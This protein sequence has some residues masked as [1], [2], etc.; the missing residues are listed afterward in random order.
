MEKR[1]L[2]KENPFRSGLLLILSEKKHRE[3]F[4]RGSLSPSHG[5][6]G[7]YVGSTDFYRRVCLAVIDEL[8]KSGIV[9]AAKTGMAVYTYQEPDTLIQALQSISAPGQFVVSS[10]NLNNEVEGSTIAA[11][12]N[13]DDLAL[14][15]AYTHYMSGAHQLI[16]F[17]DCL[18]EIDNKWRYLLAEASQMYDEIIIVNPDCLRTQKVELADLRQAKMI[19]DQDVRHE[20][21]LSLVFEFVLP[22]EE[23]MLVKL[24]SIQ[25]AKAWKR[26][27]EEKHEQAER[28]RK[29][30]K[31]KEK[32]ALLIGEVKLSLETENCLLEMLLRDGELWGATVFDSN[33]IALVSGRSE[34]GSSGGIGYYSQAVMIF[35]GQSEITEWCY[36]D[37]YDSRKD[38]WG[39]CIEKIGQI[40]T[41]QKGEK[42]WF[43]VELLNKGKSRWTEFSFAFRAE[44][45]NATLLSTEDQIV[46][47]KQI[48]EAI[49]LLLKAKEDRWFGQPE[50]LRHSEVSGQLFPGES[51]YVKYQ[52]PSL[53]RKVVL[54]HLGLAAIVLVEQIDHR[55]SD[56]QLR[57]EL[58]GL[59]FGHLESI[60]LLEDHSYDRAEGN[61]MI[62]VIDLNSREIKIRTRE[63]IKQ[64]SW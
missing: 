11:G 1:E 25:D 64:I 13:A 15:G 45:S 32:L 54:E 47:R 39:L 42:I 52:K 48:D 41:E 31:A 8:L 44:L 19:N 27:Q 5:G 57:Y 51:I 9:M 21:S 23:E 53:Q 62:S 49:S 3:I 28:A 17:S 58:Y 7:C 33:T 22:S 50:M 37:R 35:Q 40:K 60:Q 29:L 36:R 2:S 56:P 43:R 6:G 14:N 38:N 55:L 46:F 20:W 12:Y 16:I 24:G 61:A 63:G 4:G 34:W 18:E 10:V 26:F 30:V 59:K